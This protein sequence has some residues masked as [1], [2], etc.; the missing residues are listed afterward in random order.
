MN[1]FFSFIVPAF[2]RGGMIARALRSVLDQCDDSIEVVVTDDCSSDDTVAVIEAL[3][4]PRVR[5]LRHAVNR[6]VC[7]ARN[8]AIDAARGRWLVMLDS[9]FEMLPGGVAALAALCRAAAPE[10]GNV[11]TTCRWD[12]GPDTPQP[13]PGADLDLD[14]EGYCRFVAGLT[15][16]E[17]FNCYRRE[18]FETVRFPGGRA[19][20]GSFHLAV[21]RRWRFQ[22]WR[23]PVVLIHTDATNRITASAPAKM[24]AR[25]LRDAPD[26]AADAEG[27]LHAHGAV[28]RSAAPSLYE[29]FAGQAMFQHLLAG[30]RA[31]ALRWWAEGPAAARFAPRTLFFLGVGMV[32]PEA[33]AFAQTRISHW[34]NRR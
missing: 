5:L 10:V 32:G 27:V 21:A 6:G 24:A 29:K 18:V 17:W 14:F 8:T 25:M 13:A 28:F 11:A 34:K 9:D 7:A 3:G 26:G 31:D 12:A 30:H 19:Y 33:L 1:L 2:N 20:E 15:V 22:L 23:T 16:S 4:D